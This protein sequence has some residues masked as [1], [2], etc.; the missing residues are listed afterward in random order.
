MCPSVLGA[1]L[2]VVHIYLRKLVT[3]VESSPCGTSEIL[4]PSLYAL[5]SPK[6]KSH[7]P[8]CFIQ[9]CDPG[10]LSSLAFVDGFEL[11]HAI[12]KSLR[13]QR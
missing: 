1:F 11:D 6:K 7:R 4:L 2:V 10:S 9:K 12:P 13:Q 5:G 3:S 8:H